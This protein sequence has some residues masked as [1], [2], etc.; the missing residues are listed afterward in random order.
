MLGLPESPFKQR[1]L[2]EPKEI[3]TPFGTISTPLIELPP[4][5][6]LPTLE[7]RHR[8][9]L[10]HAIGTDASDIVALI[11]WA[12]GTLADNIRAMHTREIKKLLKPDEYDKYLK[13]D[14]TYPDALALLRS[15]IGV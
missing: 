14:K 12:G 13:W 1:T 15:R 7:D 3:P 5:F 11:P 6:K 4:I 10:A 8:K 2:L 9:A